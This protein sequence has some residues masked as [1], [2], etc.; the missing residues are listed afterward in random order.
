MSDIRFNICGECPPFYA[1]LYCEDQTTLLSSKSIDYS[2]NTFNGSYGKLFSSFCFLDQNTTYYIK[3]TDC[4]GKE[5]LSVPITTPADYPAY[6][7]PVKTI[8]LCGV[9]SLSQDCTCSILNANNTSNI[10]YIDPP[11]EK[12]EWIKF[13]I[14][15]TK[16]VNNTEQSLQIYYRPEGQTLYATQCEWK[17]ECYDYC[18]NI[19]SFTMYCGDEVCYNMFVKCK[20]SQ[21]PMYSC[22]SFNLN[23]D[24]ITSSENIEVTVGKPAVDINFEYTPPVSNINTTICFHYENI[25]Q[26]IPEGGGY[27]ST[28]YIVSANDPLQ[29]GQCVNVSLGVNLVNCW[30]DIASECSATSSCSYFELYCYNPSMGGLPKGLIC[31]IANDP[32]TIKQRDTAG[33]INL[34]MKLNDIYSYCAYTQVSP[35]GYMGN[36]ITDAYITNV[37]GSSNVNAIIPDDTNKRGMREQTLNSNIQ[38]CIYP[39]CESYDSSC[40]TGYRYH[41]R[42]RCSGICTVPELKSGQSF[43]LE[44][45]ETAHVCSC[46][47]PNDLT[48]NICSIACLSSVYGTFSQ[49]ALLYSGQG[50]QGTYP[51]NCT[52]YDNRCF[53]ITSSN[54]NSFRLYTTTCY[55]EDLNVNLLLETCVGLGTISESYNGTYIIADGNCTLSLLSSYPPPM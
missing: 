26:L 10:V 29:Y 48:H 52:N 47:S 39:I 30:C 34:N 53:S 24:N 28:G 37:S 19:P 50:R 14:P 27:Y 35:A 23:I 25:H 18:L 36:A 16:T 43:K 9:A 51:T 11:L 21:T 5:T 22:G 4:V 2:S 20:S 17:D 15:S 3:V 32:I 40:N 41:C 13:D 49:S 45:I 31:R 33:S 42:T 44:F 38:V 55:Y 1:Q 46:C 12:Y 8:Y 7:K 6:T 54:I